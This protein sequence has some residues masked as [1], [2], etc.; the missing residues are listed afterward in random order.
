MHLIHIIMR[1]MMKMGAQPDQ[2]YTSYKVFKSYLK[3]FLGNGL[4]ND[5]K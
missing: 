5:L 1:P 2:W 3:W 4:E